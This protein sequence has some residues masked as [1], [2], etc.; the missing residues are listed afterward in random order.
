MFYRYLCEYI[1]YK[2][3]SIN[4]KRTLFVHVPPINQPYTV[5]ELAEAIS[6][7]VKCALKQL[8]CTC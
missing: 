5:N 2:S 7:I 4:P 6:I 1:F 8:D 3:L